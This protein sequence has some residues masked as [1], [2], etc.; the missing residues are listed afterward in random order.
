MELRCA[1]YVAGTGETLPKERDLFYP[2]DQSVAPPVVS[3]FRVY[4]NFLRNFFG[5][6]LKVPGSL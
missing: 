6:I 1:V 4:E 5:K 2:V 3:K